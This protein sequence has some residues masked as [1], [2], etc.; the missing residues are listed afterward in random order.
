MY[1]AVTGHDEKSAYNK[2]SDVHF[3]SNSYERLLKKRTNLQF[4]TQV[5]HQEKYLCNINFPLINKKYGG[6]EYD[7]SNGYLVMQ[8]P[9]TT[10][11]DLSYKNHKHS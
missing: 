1:R 9:V 8:H 4:I 10:E 7:I 3:V 6:V 11:Y 5:V 2:I